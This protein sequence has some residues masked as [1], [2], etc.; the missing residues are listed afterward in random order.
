VD[1]NN[2]CENLKTENNHYLSVYQ[3]IVISNYLYIFL[4]CGTYENK[5]RNCRKVL[6]T[7]ND[8][9]SICWS[10]KKCAAVLEEWFNT[11]LT[12]STLGGFHVAADPTLGPQPEKVCITICTKRGCTSTHTT[13][14]H[15]M[16]Q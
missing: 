9:V 16:V 4:Q 6:L 11:T 3:K 7:S 12:K 8:P 14:P 13:L 15:S 5:I 2:G 10:I 1:N